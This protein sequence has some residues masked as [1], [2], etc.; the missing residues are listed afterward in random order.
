MAA[1]AILTMATGCG[2]EKAERP[3]IVLITIDTLRTDRLGA[4]GYDRDLTPHIDELADNGVVFERAVT[5]AGTTWPAHASM[6]T[7]LYPRY[8]GL[9]RNGLELDEGVPLVTE[10]LE[11]S[12]YST[13]SFVSF[14]A[15]HFRGLLHRGFQVAS[16]SDFIEEGE[17]PIR[18]GE[19]TTAMALEWLDSRSGATG[20]S[21]LWLHLFE[22]HGPYEPTDYSSHWME[23]NG[24]SGFLAD[25]AGN[26][27]LHNKRREIVS[28]PDHIAAMNALYDGEI[29]QADMLVGRVID[30]LAA[31][32][33]LSNSIV[34]IASDHGQG[35]GEQGNM[36]H[37]ATL[38]ED[39]LHIP[40]VIRDFRT[41]GGKRVMETVSAVD[42]APTIA[43][44]ALEIDLPGVQ[45]RSLM[46]Y[47]NGRAEEVAQREVFA[48]IELKKNLDEAPHWYDHES[49]AIYTEELKFVSQH[50]ET[51]VY[52]PGPR[53]SSEE[54]LEQPSINESLVA[55]LDSLRAEF[56]AGEVKPNEVELTDKEVETLKSLGYIQ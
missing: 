2:N 8:H 31:S 49:M 3:N 29:K 11:E 32:G 28:S 26:E 44:A 41:S 55:Y 20:P 22:P 7:G 35:L 17:E 37:G 5:T 4:Y 46:P 27:E 54:K 48:E 14:K 40:L 21:F 53:P 42:F 23:E 38:R 12:G 39:V 10:L 45:G 34:I 50:G 19:K 25:G 24:Y 52:E 56:L 9:R 13:G 51:T 33:D 6:L 18:D 1:L 16:D 36:G 30:H 43:D 47:I 15:M